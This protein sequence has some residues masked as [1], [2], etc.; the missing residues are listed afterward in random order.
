MMQNITFAVTTPIYFIIY[1]LTSPAASRSPKASDLSVKWRDTRPLPASTVYS[2]IIPA[3]L[4]SLP[5]PSVLSAGAHYHWL[6]TWQLFPVY[7]TLYRLLEWLVY[8][9]LRAGTAPSHPIVTADASPRPSAS[10]S[11]PASSRAR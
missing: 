9:T 2:F 4:M 11:P 3:A 10:S 1:L 8:T 7:H 6:S 5:S